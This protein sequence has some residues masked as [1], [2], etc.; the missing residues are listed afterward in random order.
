MRCVATQLYYGLV[1]RH[2]TMAINIVH[3]RLRLRL[4]L[5]LLSVLPFPIEQECKHPNCRGCGKASDCD[6]SDRTGRNRS[7]SRFSSCRRGGGVRSACRARCRTGNGAG[8]SCRRGEII[9]GS[10]SGG[11]CAAN[12]RVTSADGIAYYPN[13]GRASSALSI[14]EGSGSFQAMV[15]LFLA[16]SIYEWRNGCLKIY[17]PLEASN[18][19]GTASSSVVITST[20]CCWCRSSRGTITKIS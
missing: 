20:S 6:T 5:R 17:L 12:N 19:L 7:P 1:L 8:S 16:Y 9:A 18:P 11:G 10:G 2:I 4:G 3:Q 14:A 15:E 13:V